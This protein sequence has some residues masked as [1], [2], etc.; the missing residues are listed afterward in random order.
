MRFR[1]STNYSD[2]SL[3][4]KWRLMAFPVL[5]PTSFDCKF[6]IGLASLP[7]HSEAGLG[8]ENMVGWVGLSLS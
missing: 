6:L 4:V 2:N 5:H 8:P 3:I 1:P 7:T